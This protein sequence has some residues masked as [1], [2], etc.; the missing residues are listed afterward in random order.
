MHLAPLA[1][2]QSSG[3]SVELNPVRSVLEEDEDDEEPPRILL[4]HGKGGAAVRRLGAPLGRAC[5]AATAS[6]VWLLRPPS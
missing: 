2:R 3:E 1:D 4:Y 5:S 6:D